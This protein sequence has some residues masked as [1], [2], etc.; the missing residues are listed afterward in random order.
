MLQD[1]QFYNNIQDYLT[2]SFAGNMIRRAPNGTAP[3]FAL[4]SMMGTGTALSV[5]HGYFAKTMLFPQLTMG[6]AATDAATTFTV[7]DTTQILEGDQFISPSQELIL[8]TSVDSATQV[9][10]LRSVGQVTASAIAN[11]DVLYG[12]GN[13]HEQASDRPASRLMNPVRVINN[14]QIFRNSWA[15][16]KTMGVIKPIVGDDLISES[17]EDAGMLHSADIEKAMLFGQKFGTVHKGQYM[18][19]MDGIIETVRRL[20]PAENTT[21][22]AGNMTF[23]SLEAALDPVFD[24]MSNGQ[25]PNDRLLFVGGRARKAINKIG[26]TTG[27][28]QI[29]DDRTPFGLQFQAFKIS[30]GGFSMIEHPILNS[31][32]VWSGYAIAVDMSTIKLMHLDG[33][34][35]THIPYGIDGR[36][37]DNGI[38]AVGG[39]LTTELTMELTNPTAHAVITGITGA[40]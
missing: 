6:A 31:N 24:T 30:R 36:H 21:T 8:V 29:L 19:G 27:Q 37:T 39:T 38:D 7:T 22:A 33:R 18:T 17:R 9:T 20:A 3:L 16:P 15:L 28:Y 40:A 5:E 12:V 25:N 1:F 11:G 10:V 23:D 2:K 26:R 34:Q 32:P 4:T 13:M 14:T 35:T